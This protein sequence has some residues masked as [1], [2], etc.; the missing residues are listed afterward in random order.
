[1]ICEHQ[2]NFL[3]DNA[4]LHQLQSGF[5]KSHSTETA[6]VRLVD[7]LLFDLDRN[8]VSG[9]VFVD[10]KKGLRLYWPPAA[11]AETQNLW[12]SRKWSGKFIEYNTIRRKD[13]MFLDIFILLSYSILPLRYWAL[14]YILQTLQTFSIYVKIDSRF[15]Q[16]RLSPRIYGILRRSDLVHS[17]LLNTGLIIF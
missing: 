12:S 7:Q 1:M 10:C 5:R 6:L 8:N 3:N 16:F 14:C 13:K 2:H 15:D 17:L 4:L 11:A 9:L